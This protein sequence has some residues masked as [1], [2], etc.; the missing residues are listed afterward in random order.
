MK[1][2]ASVAVGIVHAVAAA[3]LAAGC[4]SRGASQT[5]ENCVDRNGLVVDDRRCTQEQPRWNSPGYLP[6]YHWYYTRGSYPLTM[7]RPA[8]GGTVTRP[9][10]AVSHSSSG[11]SV[12]RGGFGSTGS[13]HASSGA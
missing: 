11:H 4:G 1:R 13:A 5:W 6:Y 9:S 8:F 2:S 10:G 12:S 7:G 3:A